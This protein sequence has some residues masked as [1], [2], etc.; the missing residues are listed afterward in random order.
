[1]HNI[2]QLQCNRDEALIQLKSE[3]QANCT[4]RICDIQNSTLKQYVVNRIMT[5]Q[6]NF[7]II[8]LKVIIYDKAHILTYRPVISTLALNT[9]AKHATSISAIANETRK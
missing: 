8:F 4:D 2:D 9:M 1:M 7:I 3:Y 6:R 5:F